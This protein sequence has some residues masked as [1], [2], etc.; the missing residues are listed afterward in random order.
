MQEQ[1]QTYRQEGQWLAEKGLLDCDGIYFAPG[2]DAIPLLSKPEGSRLMDLSLWS[3]D[4]PAMA[5]LMERLGE[6]P[7]EHIGT[8]KGLKDDNPNVHVWDKYQ[9]AVGDLL[10]S[11]E[12]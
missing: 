5:T 1:F 11:T 6:D 3:W 9:H 12:I 10:E 2:A 4:V 8:Y 7:A